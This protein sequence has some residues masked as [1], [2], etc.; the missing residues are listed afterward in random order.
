M[1]S[2]D[3]DEPQHL[4]PVFVGVGSNIEP[5]VHIPK[6]L[7]LLAERFGALQ[8]SQAYRCPA[9]GFDGAAF[10]NLVVAFNV[11]EPPLAVLHGL[12]DIEQRCGRDRNEKKQSR[13]LDLDLLL[14]DN[15]VVER[16]GLHLPRSDI[17]RYA[18]V[19]KPLAMMIPDQTHPVVGRSYAELWA[20]FDARDQPLTPVALNIP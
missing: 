13:T 9:V 3:T 5:R 15:Q 12:R 18:F 4:K 6:G 17:L 2:F 20:D 7:T 16:D 8:V 1:D 10:I 19:L 14:H 11:T